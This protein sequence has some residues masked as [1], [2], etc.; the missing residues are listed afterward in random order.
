MSLTRNPWHVREYTAGELRTLLGESF[1]AVETL[2]VFGNA[3]A[4]A[5]YEENRRSVQRLLRFDPLDLQHRLPRRLLQ[6]PYDPVSYTH[7]SISKPWRAA[8]ASPASSR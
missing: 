4:M 7:L 1:A 3:K 8:T 6:L 2:G 5:Y